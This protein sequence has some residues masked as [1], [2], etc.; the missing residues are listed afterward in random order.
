MVAAANR[1]KRWAVEVWPGQEGEGQKKQMVIE[2]REL[3]PKR[4]TRL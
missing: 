1:P 4:S 2:G 3:R